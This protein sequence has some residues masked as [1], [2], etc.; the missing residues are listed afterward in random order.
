MK[1]VIAPAAYLFVI[2]AVSTTLLLMAYAVT[3]EPIQNQVRQTQDRMMR[4]VLPQADEFQEISVDTSGTMVSVFEATAHGQRVGLVVSAAPMGYAG[5]IELIVGISSEENVI[6]GMRI[7]RHTE[8]PGFG[9]VATN[10]RFYSQFDNRP[11]H[12]ITVVR[13]G[14]GEYELDSIAASTIT[15]EAIVQGVNDAI[16]WYKGG[17]F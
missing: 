15:T 16:E 17:G 1:H 12:P 2:A 10:E 14:A 4:A 5:P 7:V 13:S 11:L 6:S 8:T 3:F 9:S